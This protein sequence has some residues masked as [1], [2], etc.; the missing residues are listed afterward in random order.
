MTKIVFRPRGPWTRITKTPVTHPFDTTWMKTLDL[1]RTEAYN[2]KRRAIAYEDEVVIEVDVAEKDIRIDG[3]LRA[4]TSVGSDGVRVF[5]D[6]KHGPLVYA[7][8]NF[9]GHGKLRG[10]QANVRAIA[11]ALENLRRVDRYGVSGHGEQY[12]GWVALDPPKPYGAI[13]V[14]VSVI[15]WTREQVKADQ[16]GAYRQALKKAHPDHGGTR[17]LLQA[18]MTA[19]K[20][21]G[22]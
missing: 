17:E 6:S 1:L 2:L 14:I 3:H 20:E 16:V 19:G 7:C 15:G 8:D 11:V 13:D 18:V 12:K 21:L 10:W 9:T 4:N 22:L 5:I